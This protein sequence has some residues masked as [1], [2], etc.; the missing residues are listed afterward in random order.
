MTHAEQSLYYNCKVLVEDDNGLF[1]QGQR[2]LTG[3]E[4]YYY[5]CLLVYGYK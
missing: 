4:S 2:S 1:Y 3:L 5:L